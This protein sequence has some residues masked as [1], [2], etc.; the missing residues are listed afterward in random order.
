MDLSVL[1]NNNH[2]D[3]FLQLDVKALAVTPNLGQIGLPGLSGAALSGQHWHNQVY[4]Q[5]KNQKVLEKLSLRMND[6]RPAV[7]DQVLSKHITPVTLKT[8]IK[9][10]PLFEDIREVD[11]RQQSKAHP[12]WTIQEYDRHSVHLNLTDYLTKDP[13]DLK[14][15][16]DDIYTPGYDSLLKKKELEMK[17]AKC[18]KI[19]TLLALVACA[20]ITVITVS[21]VI[22]G[23]TD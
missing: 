18:C 21:L 22:V 8:T 13:N 6:G 14:F 19:I 4:S 15:W 9:R 2:P 11:N 20:L 10:N 5:T 17:R 23:R 7:I 16:M 12:S 3:K 1:P